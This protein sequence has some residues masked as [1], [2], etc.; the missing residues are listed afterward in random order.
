MEKAGCIYK[1]TNTA[2]AKA[3]IGKTVQSPDRRWY[4]HKYYAKNG[5]GGALYNAIRKYGEDKFV[6]E[7]V[8]S[9]IPEALLAEKEIHYIATFNTCIVDGNGY[10]YNMTR[11]GDG[12]DSELSYKLQMDKVASGTHHFQ[13]EQGRK[14][15]MDRIA[16]GTHNFTPENR[17]EYQKGK[18][19]S[20][21]H[22]DKVGAGT[23]ARVEAG[24]HPWVG[25]EH[26]KRLIEQGLHSSCKCYT[27]PYCGVEGK[28]GAMRRWHFEN[29][30]HK[31][32]KVEFGN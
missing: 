30:K 20:Q 11:G 7:V 17:S 19:L 12:G 18:K 5:H 14:L 4:L 26:T 24:T 13:G 32:G 10:G 3:Y 23:K 22:K 29:C 1:I 8:E 16:N 25:G 2:N 15:Q 6:F 27:C 31:E 28:G 9:D 21:E